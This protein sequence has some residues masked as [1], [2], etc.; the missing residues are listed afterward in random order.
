[1]LYV[2]DIY[3]IQTG[4]HFI[5]TS[6]FT[7]GDV[8]LKRVEF[9]DIVTGELKLVCQ[10]DL[11]IA[12]PECKDAIGMLHSQ[13]RT[14]S[15]DLVQFIRHINIQKVKITHF[16]DYF[17]ARFLNCCS[18]NYMWYNSTA[19]SSNG[20]TY[21]NL[22]EMLLIAQSSN[23]NES[24]FSA[25]EHYILLHDNVIIK[26]IMDMDLSVAIAKYRVRYGI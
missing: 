12:Y 15:F 24:I 18:K 23:L 6:T 25:G 5:E 7:Y 20:N 16:V 13:I 8:A 2:A 11:C 9:R 14:I 10:P 17:D 22:I 26:V 3:N 19:Y 1:M 21:Y 4:Q